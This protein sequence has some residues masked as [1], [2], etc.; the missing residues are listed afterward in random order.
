VKAVPFHFT[1]ELEG[2]RDQ[3]SLNGWKTY[4]E[5]YMACNELC[6]MVYRILH[7]AHLKEVGLPQNCETMT[8][9]L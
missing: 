6:F 7:Q 9:D 3:G 1:L 5:S 4:M 8:L 2:I